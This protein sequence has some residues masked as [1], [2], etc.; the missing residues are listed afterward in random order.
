MV[1]SYGFRGNALKS[2]VSREIEPDVIGV[3]SVLFVGEGI[4][5]QMRRNPLRK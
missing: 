1:L 3:P 2:V 5:G 4:N